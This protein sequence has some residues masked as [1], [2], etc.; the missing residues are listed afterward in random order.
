MP[1]IIASKLYHPNREKAC[2]R[3]CFGSGEHAEWC[4]ERPQQP[5][6]EMDEINRVTREVFERMF[7]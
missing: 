7:R 6:R 2:E 5:K 1:E 3:C 4:P